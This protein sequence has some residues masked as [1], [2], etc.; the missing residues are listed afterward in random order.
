MMESQDA[1]MQ[2]VTIDSNCIVK[3]WN[4][5]IEGSGEKGLTQVTLEMSG[6]CL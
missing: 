2:T 3:A 5:F 1:G 6:V 4:N